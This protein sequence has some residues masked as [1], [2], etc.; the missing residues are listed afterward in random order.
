MKDFNKDPDDPG[1]NHPFFCLIEELWLGDWPKQLTRMNE[2]IRE[3][4]LMLMNEATEEE[5]WTFI[6]I[7]ILLFATHVG[8]GEVDAMFDKKKKLINQFPSIDFT[9][10]M[11]QYRFKQIKK[12]FHCKQ[13]TPIWGP[14]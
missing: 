11:P 9:E 2:H 14:I 7:G 5:W 4:E 8:K 10:M 1:Y 13:E 12:V 6:G 3:N